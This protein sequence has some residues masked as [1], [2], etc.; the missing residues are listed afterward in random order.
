MDGGGAAGINHAAG[1][2]CNVRFVAANAF[3]VDLLAAAVAA[4]HTF[5]R[6]ESGMVRDALSWSSGGVKCTS[7]AVCQ[8]CRFE[9]GP[10][11]P[12]KQG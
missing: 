8:Y 7:R 11:R 2:A 4:G 10:L 12:G 1:D 9:P 3:D 6:A 5:L